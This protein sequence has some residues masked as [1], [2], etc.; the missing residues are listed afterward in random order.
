MFALVYNFLSNFAPRIFKKLNYQ[1]KKWQIQ[2][3]L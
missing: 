2:N 1:D 3:I